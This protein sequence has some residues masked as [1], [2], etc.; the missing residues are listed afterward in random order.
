MED[1]NNNDEKTSVIPSDTFKGKLEAAANTPPFL[2]VLVG[3]GKY[4]GVQWELTKPEI[5]VGRSLDADICLDE[6]S[7][8]KS[9]VRLI[10]SDASVSILDL[11]ST[12]KT[13]INGRQLSPSIPVE[14][15]D[16]DQV[17]MGNI[18]FKYLAPGNLEA[19]SNQENFQKAY[20]DPLTGI[21]NK[22]AL[23]NK[24]PDALKRARLLN[25]DIC[26]IVFDIDHF[27]KVNDTFGHIA[28]DY[29]LKELTHIIKKTQIR[30]GDFFARFGGEEFIL[31]LAQSSKTKGLDVA[32]RIRKTIEGHNFE[33]EKKKI[34]LTISLGLCSL[35]PDIHDWTALL[36]KADEALYRSKL[37]GR[38]QVSTN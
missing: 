22:R 12:N 33:F 27:K 9:H 36:A 23:E 31:I 10:I 6:T 37:N 25:E 35:T 3:P 13:Y 1:Q 8:S 24:G 19:I 21:F 29:V 18:I 26:A 15:R 2:V 7:I 11:Q 38:N 16:S 32:E 5:V 17:Q 34:P 20:T 30:A 4:T 28:G 14:L